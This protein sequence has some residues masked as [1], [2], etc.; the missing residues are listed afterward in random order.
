MIRT[1]VCFLS[2]ALF[3]T[4]AVFGQTGD[5]AS[6]PSA[7]ELRSEL[8]FG[9]RIGEDQAATGR[10]KNVALAAGLSAVLPGAGQA[11]NG[12]WVKAAAGV[13]IEA[14]LI[15]AYASWQRDGRAAERAFQAYAHE[16]WDPPQYARWLMDY[17][18]WLPAAES[19]QID[20]PGGVD[21]QNPHTWTDAERQRGLMFRESV[22]SGL[23]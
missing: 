8:R 21:F 3:S 19:M 14:A 20:I 23:G 2:L 9:T 16:H 22:P 13:A 15:Y 6:N 18:D 17:A 10:P 4:P 7:A 1:A 12:H 11:Y 5:A